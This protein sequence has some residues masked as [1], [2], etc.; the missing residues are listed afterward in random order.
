[1]DMSVSISFI[2]NQTKI[3][4]VQTIWKWTH[5][6][7]SSRERIGKFLYVFCFILGLILASEND[8]HR[9]LSNRYHISS[10]SAFNIAFLCFVTLYSN[11]NSGFFTMNLNFFRWQHYSPCQG[12]QNLILTYLSDFTLQVLASK[13]KKC[14]FHITVKRPKHSSWIFAPF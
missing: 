9:P 6:S 11:E 8:R 5:T 13:M 7:D 14:L 3:N 4:S 1:M 10:L 2:Y 12:W